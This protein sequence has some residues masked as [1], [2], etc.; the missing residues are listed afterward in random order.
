MF[1]GSISRS[2][3]F[4]YFRMLLI[5]VTHDFTFV[6]NSVS[7]HLLASSAVPSE[8]VLIRRRRPSLLEK[9][10]WKGQMTPWRRKG[11]NQHLF[12]DVCYFCL[13]LQFRFNTFV[14]YLCML[15][16]FRSRHITLYPD[17]CMMLAHL[18]SLLDELDQGLRAAVLHGQL[19]RSLRI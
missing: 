3:P 10:F 5:S 2:T 6:V 7:A 15:L 11:P 9:L 1:E 13:R 4:F 18:T 12:E 17:L 19:D 8:I 16:M 14:R